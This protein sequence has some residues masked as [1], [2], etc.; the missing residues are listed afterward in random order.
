MNQKIKNHLA[1]LETQYN[2]KILL[3]CE[4]GSRAWGFPSSD[5]DYDVRIIYVHPQDWYLSLNEQKDSLN[6]ML[7]DD[8]VDMSGWDLRKSLRLLAKSNAPLIERIQSPIVYQQDDDFM[9]QISEIAQ[10]NYSRISSVHHYWGM[11]KKAYADL[12]QAQQSGETYKLKRLFYALRAACVC[13][14]ILRYERMPHIEFAH[15]YQQTDVPASVVA[16]IDE[17]IALKSTVDE[18]YQHSSDDELLDFIS[19]TLDEV[20][21]KRLTLPDVRTDW[22]QLDTFSRNMVRQYDR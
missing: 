6:I 16:R 10:A 1:N 8:L 9:A 20:E 3:A 18:S 11:A 14:W 2:I 13:R 12:L 7:D 21:A 4:T 22:A 17:L 15:A 19:D 5:S